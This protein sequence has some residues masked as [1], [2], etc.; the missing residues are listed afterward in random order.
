MTDYKWNQYFKIHFDEIGLDYS[1]EWASQ[2]ALVVK[3]PPA[4]ARYLRDTSSIP[5]LW[6][7]SSPTGGGP[8]NPL[9]YSCLE[10]SMDREACQAWQSLAKHRVAKSQTWLKWLSIYA[11]CWISIAHLKKWYCTLSVSVIQCIHN[12]F[13]SL[14]NHSIYI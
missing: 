3:N 14:T 7:G 6:S 12:R 11:A 9:Q 1:A 10:N 13:G 8:G 5:G 2:V 4:N